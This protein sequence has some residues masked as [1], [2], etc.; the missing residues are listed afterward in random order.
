MAAS[1]AGR[2]LGFFSRRSILESA[3]MS[4]CM[5]FKGNS[6]QLSYFKLSLIMKE[7]ERKSKQKKEQEQEQEKEKNKKDVGAPMTVA[8]ASG[9]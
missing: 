7:R 6:S 9:R 1:A 8:S 4:F 5:S 3:S 2:Q